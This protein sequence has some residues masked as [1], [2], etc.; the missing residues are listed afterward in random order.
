MSSQYI[1]LVEETTRGTTPAGPYLFL[2][3]LGD[4]SPDFD[5]TDKPR[6]EFKGVDVALGSATAIRTEVKW[7]Y[8]LKCYWYPGKETALLFKHL[9]GNPAVRAIIDT[10]AYKGLIAPTAMP[11]GA[12]SPLG[13]SAI[14]II[15]NTDEGGVTYSQ[16]FGGG[17]I[18]DCKITCKG[19]DDIE[20][21]FTLEGAWVGPADQ[22]AIGGISFPPANPYNSSMYRAY[23]GGTPVRTGSAPLYSDITPG[24]AVQFKPDSLDITITNGLKDKVVGNGVRGPSKTTRSAQFKVVVACPIDYEDPTSGFNSSAEFKKLFSG[25]VTNNLFVTFDNGDLAGSAIQTFQAMLDLPV[26]LQQNPKKADRHT[27]GKTPG[28]K[29]GFES[30]NSSTTGYPLALM[31]VDQAVTI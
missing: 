28:L 30:L 2:P 18:T 21:E 29:L 16:T 20:L 13:D 22:A 3:I 11:Y 31:L 12:G 6:M 1:A 24:T 17:R 4:L 15:A 19:T 9:L 25:V 10:T 27:D 26:M 5:A 7:A 23:I 8:K 14:A